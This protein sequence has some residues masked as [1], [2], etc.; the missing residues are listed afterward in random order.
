MKGG[1]LGDLGD[2]ESVRGPVSQYHTVERWMTAVKLLPGT[3]VYWSWRWSQW[4]RG[5]EKIRKIFRRHPQPANNKPPTDTTRPQK[6]ACCARRLVT[7]ST[8]RGSEKNNDSRRRTF[9][10]IRSLDATRLRATYT[11][12]VPRARS[13]YERSTL[14]PLTSP[15]S[16]SWK[17]SHRLRCVRA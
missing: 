1:K 13:R 16:E 2:G 7:H 15:R 17:G 6:R 4:R 5:R 8:K 10:K 9:Q 12:K 11:S 14:S 3:R